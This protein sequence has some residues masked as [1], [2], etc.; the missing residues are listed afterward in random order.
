[1]R[2]AYVLPWKDHLSGELEAAGVVTTCLSV[3]RRDPLWPWRL[4]TAARPRSTW[5]TPTRRCRPPPPASSP[6]RCPAISG[7]PSWSPSTTR[8][9]RTAG[10]TRWTNRADGRSGCGDL[11]RHRGGPGELPR[12]GRPARRGAG[13]R[14]RRRGHPAPR[15]AVTARDPRRAG[16]GRPTTSSSARWPTS[17]RRR[18]TPTC[19][20]RPGSSSIGTWRSGWSPSVRARSRR[21]ITARRDALG[22]TDHV[23]LAGFRPDAVDVL[24]ACDGFVLASAWEGL[25]VAVMEATALG[26][27]IVATRVGGRRRAPRRR[28]RHPRPAARPERPRRADWRTI[29][30]D[31]GRRAELAARARAAAERFDIGGPPPC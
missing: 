14:T 9:A 29:V 11:G 19:S 3:R 16:A 25:P 4:R 12:P 31:A 2:A 8:R 7:R 6:G 18:T 10:S 15:R 17:G 1:M 23:V 20:P 21:D 30:G 28:R 26:L 22:L 27:P 24:R 13:A 5:S